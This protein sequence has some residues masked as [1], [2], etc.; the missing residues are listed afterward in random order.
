MASELK[1]HMEIRKKEIEAKKNEKE[2]EPTLGTRNNLRKEREKEAAFALLKE[3]GEHTV[4]VCGG[5]GAK[6]VEDANFCT[7]CGKPLAG[8]Q[9]S[10]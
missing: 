2:K 8:P 3:H 1:V 7:S 10:S 5:C 9:K 4:P 6:I